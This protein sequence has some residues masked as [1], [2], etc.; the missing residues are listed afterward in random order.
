MTGFDF[1]ARSAPYDS[2][3]CRQVAAQTMIRA[4]FFLFLTIEN[5]LNS[6]KAHFLRSHAKHE[7]GHP[8]IL[9]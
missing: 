2:A 7:K 1:G 8:A 9:A 3:P 4:L 5:T 6:T